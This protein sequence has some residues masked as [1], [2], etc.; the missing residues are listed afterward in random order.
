MGNANIIMY[1]MDKE[2]LPKFQC[3][4]CDIHTLYTCHIFYLF[5]TVLFQNCLGVTK[6]LYFQLR[7]S[8]SWELGTP[9]MPKQLSKMALNSGLVLFL[10]CTSI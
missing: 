6:F 2:A 5:K 10:R 1:F 7:Y 4:V 9:N 8:G 3:S